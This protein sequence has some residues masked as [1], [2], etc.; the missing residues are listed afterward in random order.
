M[1]IGAREMRAG[2]ENGAARADEIRIDIVF[3]KR[4]VGAIVA[5]EDEREGLVVLDGEKDEGGQPL[6]VG[7]DAFQRY[8]FTGHLFLD[9]TAH[10]LVADAG[11]E[12]RFQAKARSANGDIRRAAPYR[13]GERGDIL[14]P[15]ADLLPVEIDGRPANGNDIQFGHGFARGGRLS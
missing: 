15:C 1:I 4:A 2:N 8:A 12:A 13:F 10:L 14:E 7:D 6:L 11:D 5:I 9:E 3:R